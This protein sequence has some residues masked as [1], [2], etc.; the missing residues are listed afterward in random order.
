MSIKNK[1]S[2]E[3]AGARNVGTLIAVVCATLAPSVPHADT[4]KPR[5]VIL[6]TGGTIAGRAADP[7]SGITYTPGQIDAQELIAATPGLGT[8]A[9]LEAEKIAAVGSQDMT[10]DVWLRLARRIQELLSRGEADGIVVTHGT[11]SLEET[12]FFLDLVLPRGR[13]VVV[14]GATRP[15]AALGADGPAN[16]YAAV[17]TAASPSARDRGVLAVLNGTIHTARSVQ[18]THTTALETFRSPNTGPAGHVD[19]HGVHFYAQA[20]SS[21]HGQYPL[22]PAAP[23]PRVEIIY[24]HAQMDDAV[25]ESAVTRGA[26]GLVLAGF[27]PGNASKGVIAALHRAVARGL[28][29]VRSTRVGQGFVDRNVEIDDDELGF[30]ASRDLNPHKA[31]ILTQILIANGITDPAAVQRAFE[32]T[33]AYTHP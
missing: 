28:A 32:L 9:R 26:R 22:P 25:V 12:A 14:V 21:A 6:T 3:N 27:G 13:P 17:E 19:A 5:V 4:A 30:V 20:S 8:L 1:A 24:A 11:D 10:D 33:P 2:G 29:V 16:L 31:R 18:K 7:G 23:F 15:P